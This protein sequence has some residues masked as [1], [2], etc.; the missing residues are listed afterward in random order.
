MK[1]VSKL[2]SYDETLK[3]AMQNWQDLDCWI[4]LAQII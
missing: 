1:C 3:A 4:I 2:I